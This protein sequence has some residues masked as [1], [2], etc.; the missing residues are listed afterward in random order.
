MPTYQ[1]KNTNTWYCKFY[2][3]DWNGI[4][5]QK[6][7][8]GFKLRREAKEFERQFLEQFAKNPTITFQELYNR[9]KEYVSL[10]L[11]ESTISSRFSM[12][13]VHIL[14][15]F[16]NRIIS[17]I[18]PADIITWQNC[19]LKKNLSDTY[20][21]Q[22]NVYLKAMFSYGVDYIGLPKNPCGKY[23]GVPQN[24]KIKFLDAGRISEIYRNTV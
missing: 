23:I 13:D 19:M 9:Y 20:L 14:P 16:K 18:T 1:D 10:R 24:P 21:N 17:D 15:Y 12:I 4:R 6:L 5:K 7:K 11:R 2:Y 3:E 22:I 8:R